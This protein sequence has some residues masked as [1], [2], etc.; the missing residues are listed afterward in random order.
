MHVGA[1]EHREAGI[2]PLECEEEVGPAEQNDLG[3]LLPAQ[4]LAGGEKHAPLRIAD[5]TCGC[6]RHIVVMHLVKLCA[7]H[8]SKSVMDETA[9]LYLGESLRPVTHESDHTEFI[10]VRA[11][12][13]DEV[14]RMVERS[15]ITDAMTVI[16]VLHVARR[17]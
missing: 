8:T 13:F 7:F 5:P 9:H 3:A 14:V 1:I 11:F 6:H 10:E 16:A 12:P 2:A 17:R 15:E 4:A